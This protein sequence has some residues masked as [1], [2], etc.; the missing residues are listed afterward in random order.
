MN[1][2]MKKGIFWSTVITSMVLVM[3]FI[4]NLLGGN[5]TFAAGFHEHERGMGMRPQNGFGHERVMDGFHHGSGFSWIGFLLFLIIGL[6]VLVIVV[7]WLKTKSK[8]ASMQQFIDTSLMTSSKPSINHN[9]AS[10]LDQWE[11]N[12]TTKKENK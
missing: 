9:H 6:A 11:K 2:R 7:K 8:T 1:T 3:S 10:I 5:V 12:I 4:S